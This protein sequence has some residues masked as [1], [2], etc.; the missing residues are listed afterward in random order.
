MFGGFMIML[1]KAAREEAV[2]PVGIII[3][4][5]DQNFEIAVL[6]IVPPGV[7]GVAVEAAP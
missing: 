4:V 5:E 3:L 1:I 7:G 2:I 6:I